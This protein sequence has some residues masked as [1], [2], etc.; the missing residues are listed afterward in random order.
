[1]IKNPQYG[2]ACLVILLLAGCAR[3]I[4]SHV[5]SDRHVGEASSSYQGT[6]LSIRKV[7]VGSER[8]QDNVAGGVVGAVS[9][10]LLGSAFGQGHGRTAMTAVGAVGGAVAGAAAERALKEQEALEY[11]VKLNTGKILTVVQGLE[12]P[13]PVGSRVIVII[14]RA[15]RSRV[16]RDT[17]GT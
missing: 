14:G 17:T 6:V 1:M 9:G 2:I 10:G 8:L 5:Y 3:Q 7:L 13:L 15:G 4:G 16:I 11:V 12:D